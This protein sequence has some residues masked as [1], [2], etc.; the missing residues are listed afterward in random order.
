MSTTGPV[1]IY[2]GLPEEYL[3]EAAELF[4]DSFQQKF[5]QIMDNREQGISFLEK[6]PQSQGHNGSL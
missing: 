6:Q 4:Y 5:S 3:Q 2:I 1:E